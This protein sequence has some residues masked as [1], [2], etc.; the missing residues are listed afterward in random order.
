MGAERQRALS[1]EEKERGHWTSCSVVPP[2][3]GSPNWPTRGTFQLLHPPCSL[4]QPRC[5]GPTT[6]SRH[7]RTQTGL[8][9]LADKPLAL[10]SNP[11][12]D[13]CDGMTMAKLQ[14]LSEPPF[15][16]KMG[17]ALRVSS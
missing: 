1:P 8:T 3:W 15:L 4:S 17:V 16:R 14:A 7:P 12:L 10:S 2:A 9:H 5:P 13:T 11:G 6:V